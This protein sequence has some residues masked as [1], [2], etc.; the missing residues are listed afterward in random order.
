LAE[1]KHLYRLLAL[2]THEDMY[3]DDGEKR[4]AREAFKNLSERHRQ[5]ET[6]ID[7]GT[8]GNRKAPVPHTSVSSSVVILKDKYIRY[9]DFASG[10]IADLHAACI[11][12]KKGRTEVLLK[13]ARNSADNELLEAE[14][15][16]L[17][18]LREGLVNRSS[19][20][21]DW[22]QCIP[23]IIDSFQVAVGSSR[24]RVNVLEKFEGFINIEQIHKAYPTGIDG[25]SIAWMWKRLLGMLDWTHKLGFLHGAVLPPH[26]MYYPDNDGGT[27][28][29]IRKHAV[30]LIDWCY[31]CRLDRRAKLKAWVPNYE[32]FYAPEIL[33]KTEL[34]AASDLYMGAK[35]MLYLL[36]GDVNKNTFPTH[37]PEPVAASLKRCLHRDPDRRPQ[38]AKTCLDEF[39]KTLERVYGPPKYHEF[40]MPSGK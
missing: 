3:Q 26:V 5:A 23:Q 6:K 34:V 11:E 22:A 27:I 25:R 14:R 15:I 2:K 18:E 13:A 1:L 21:S 24:V 4:L 36:G 10:D 28:R 7:Q 8:Y 37:V 31:S 29:D 39:V 40:N 33:A 38:E 20:P 12:N 17:S 30:R 19:G 9:A 32:V 35:T 16:A